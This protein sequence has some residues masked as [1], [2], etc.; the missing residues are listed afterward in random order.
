MYNFF[1][2]HITVVRLTRLSVLLHEKRVATTG[3]GSVA[4]K[5]VAGIACHLVAQ[6]NWGKD[7]LAVKEVK[8]SYDQLDIARRDSEQHCRRWSLPLAKSHSG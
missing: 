2:N 5:E 6:A 1:D 3:K 8:T 7:S 4:V